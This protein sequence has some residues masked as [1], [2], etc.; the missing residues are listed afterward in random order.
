MM[1]AFLPA[2]SARRRAGRACRRFRAEPLR[3]GPRVCCG[4]PPPVRVDDGKSTLVG[5]LLHDSKSVLSDSSTRWSGPRRRGD[6]TARIFRCWSTGCGPSAS[7][8]S[9]STSPTG[10]S[11]P[12]VRSFILADTPGHVQYTRNTITGAS[13]ADLVV[14]LVDARTGVVAQTRRHAA[15]AALLGVPHLLLAV[16]KID[17]VDFDEA[18]FDR[19]AAEF[20]RLCGGPRH[21][22]GDGNSD[23][24]AARRQRRRAVGAHRLVHR[25]RA[26]SST[27]NTLD[28]DNTAA[29]LAGLRFPVQYVIRPRSAR[30]SRTTAATPGRVA[31]GTVRPGRR[32]GG[33]A[34]R[35]DVDG[36]SGIDTADG[37]MDVGHGR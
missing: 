35:A 24:G 37:P 27:W 25:A 32:G 12:A 9:P 30:A 6:W 7:R 36:Q 11:P 18:V 31:A 13:T 33:A 1:T 29:V 16:N 5:R 21:R 28:L 17:L 8:A 15:V 4:S 26:F 23:L 20:D 34:V 19:I 22:R 10:T 2:D 14:I 3:A